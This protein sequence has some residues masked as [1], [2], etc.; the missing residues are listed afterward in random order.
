[1]FSLIF[2]FIYSGFIA[3][4]LTY[5]LSWFFIKSVY[6]KFTTTMNAY[7]NLQ[8]DLCLLT[9]RTQKLLDELEKK[10]KNKNLNEINEDERKER[11]NRIRKAF[12]KKE[13]EQDGSS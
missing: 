9:D 7:G 3:L 1:M 6:E 11:W 4:L 13:R 10:S 12:D 5:F 8:R 2:T